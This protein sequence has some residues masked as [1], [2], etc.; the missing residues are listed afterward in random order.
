MTFAMRLGIDS[1][2]GYGFYVK[3]NLRMRPFWV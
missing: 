2:A 3:L 1:Q